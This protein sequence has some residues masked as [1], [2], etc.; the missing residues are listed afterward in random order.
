MVKEAKAMV[1]AGKLGQI[2]K[3]IAEYPQGWLAEKLED[4]G[5]KQ[6]DWRTDP[7]RAGISCCVGDIGSHAENLT[8]Y[9]TG[10]KIT[11][12]AADV[13][14]FVEGRLLDDDRKI[15]ERFNNG[16]KGIIIG[17]Q[18]AVGEEN[19][20]KIRLYGEKGSLEWLQ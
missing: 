12:V 2:R 8:E 6:A 16:A 4:S 1:K 9:I 15:V 7:K 20:L 13:S 10:L 17:S 5:Q 3:V 19:E 11:E 14:T 18:I